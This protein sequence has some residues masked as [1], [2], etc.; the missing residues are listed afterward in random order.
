MHRHLRVAA[1]LTLAMAAPLLFADARPGLTVHETVLR[2]KPAGD[3]AEVAKLPAETEL[4]VFERKGGWYR[5]ESTPGAGWLRLASLRFPSTSTSDAVS[6]VDLL[7][8][9]MRTGSAPVGAASSGTTTGVRGLDASDL[10]SASPSEGQVE[11]LEGYASNADA[12][13]KFAAAAGLGA[14]DVAY[15]EPGEVDAALLEQ[16]RQARSAQERERSENRPAIE[17]P[18]DKPC[19]G[20]GCDPDIPFM[21]GG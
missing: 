5:V 4:A 8:N 21:G 7:L 11:K 18:A 10:A 1:W 20:T 12:G 6:G 15:L 17:A 13:R 14:V 3:A 9:S 16:T 19:F 2:A